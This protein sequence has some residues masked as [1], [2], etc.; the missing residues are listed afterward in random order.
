MPQVSMEVK[1][2]LSNNV[3]ESEYWV[4]HGDIL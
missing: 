4:F 2:C 3:T 1:G